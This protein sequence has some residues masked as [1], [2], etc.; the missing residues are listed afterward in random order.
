VR[1]LVDTTVVVDVLRGAPGLRERLRA[2]GDD[3]L[4]SAMTIHEIVL[5]LSEGQE[6][7]FEELLAAT[8]VVP[9]GAW[10]ARVAAGWRRNYAR[11]GV[12]LDP[13]DTIIA[14]SA[15]THGAVLATA[16]VRHFPMEELHVEEWS[17]GG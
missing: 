16:N 7:L 10:E 6:G 8:H 11:R 1:L 2:A 3:V 14:A 9:I 17:R 5:G 12:T 15:F 4:V 13:P